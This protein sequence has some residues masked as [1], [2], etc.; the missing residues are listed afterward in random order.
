[1]P[2]FELFLAIFELETLI[3]HNYLKRYFEMS[4][5]INTR[6]NTQNSYCQAKENVS[7]QPYFG[8]NKPAN[9]KP[10]TGLKAASLLFTMSGVSL[11]MLNIAK[12]QKIK[13]FETKKIS[14]IFKKISKLKYEGKEVIKMAVGSVLGGL[15]AGLLFD[16]EH[17]KSKFMEATQQMVGNILIPI[18]LVTLT[19]KQLNKN[20]KVLFKDMKEIPKGIIKGIGTLAALAVGIVAGNFAANKINDVVF[21][22]KEKRTIQLGDFSAHLDDIGIISILIAPDSK[23]TQKIS[24]FIPLAL[25]VSGYETGIDKTLVEKK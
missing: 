3:I 20:E 15:T 1:M 5:N 2:L 4:V 14:D 8:V 13:I 11:A 16:S 24:P 7:A 18:G 19:A 22:K 9:Q 10:N 12:C 6:V 25:M 21:D 23:F 17:S